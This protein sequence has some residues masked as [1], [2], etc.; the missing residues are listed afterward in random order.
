MGKVVVIGPIGWFEVDKVAL[1]GPELV[2]E[3]TEKVLLIRKRLRTTK[4]RQ[5]SYDGVI[6]RDLELD[7]NDWVYLK[8]SSMKGATRFRK[9]GNLSPRYVGPYQI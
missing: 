3:A 6:R 5:K 8:T 7:V 1:I 9:T 2:H 4:S